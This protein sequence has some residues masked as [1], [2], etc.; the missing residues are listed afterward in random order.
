[1]KI[2][3]FLSFIQ[4]EKRYSNHTLEAYKTDLG[5][6]AVY[7][8]QQY[9]IISPEMILS[10]HVRSWIVS[11]VVQGITPKSISRK[12][13]SLKSYFKFLQSNKLIAV[14]PAVSIS[15]PKLGKRLPGFIKMEEMENLFSNNYF[16]TTPEGN[17]HRLILELLYNCGLRRSELILLEKKNIDLLA[18]RIKVLGKNNKERL[19]PIGP[20]LAQSIQDYLKESPS[21]FNKGEVYLFV[22]KKGNKLNPRSVYNIVI[23]Y[24]NMVTKSDN[25]APHILRHSFATHLLENGADLNAVKTL[26]GHASLASTQVYTHNTI[27]RLKKSYDN[28]HPK[29]GK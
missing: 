22:S 27:E 8:E 4:H 1:M 20:K 25:K 18:R 7:L 29:S 26:L 11:L 19:I 10:T 14:N 21:D 2:E 24:L 23:K 13:S 3:P 17:Q 28:A 12:L 9:E 15:A 5:Q 6:F 16:E